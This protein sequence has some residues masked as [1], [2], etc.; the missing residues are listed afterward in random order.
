MSRPEP[1]APPY[2]LVKA[3]ETGNADAQ[4][5]LGR[6][7]A[8]NLP[9]TPYA[10]MW[11]RRAAAQGLPRALHNLGVLA[12][13]S[14]DHELAIEWFR[15]A[16]AA[17]W[18]NSMYLLGRLLE[19]KGDL[20]GAL[21][22]YNRGIAKDCT[23]SMHA[24]SKLIIDRQLSR[25][26]ESARNMC[27]RA[28]AQGHVGA[29]AQLAQI[30]HEGLGVQPDPKQAI[31]LW[32]KAAWQGHLGAQLMIGVTC[33]IG[34]YLK[35]DRVAAMRFLSA[36]AA[37][38][39]EGAEACLRRV[40]RNLTPEERAE[41]ERE[42]T[43]FAYLKSNHST[44]APP[45]HLLWAAEAGDVESQNDLGFWYSQHLP[46]SSEAQMWFTRAADQGD[47]N[48]RHNLGAEAF[49]AGDMPLAA[50]W[51]KKAIAAGTREY[52]IYLGTILERNGDAVGATEI[53]QRGADRN[54]PDCQCS[55][56]RLAFH[57][58]T[59]E[60]YGRAR[61]WDEKAA[62]HGIAASQ[63][64][65]GMMYHQGLGLEPDP[66]Q[67]VHW[68]QQAA[69]QGHHVAQYMMGVACHKGAGTSRDR[70]AAMRFLKASA[71]QGNQEAKDYL[72]DR[73]GRAY[74]WGI[75]RA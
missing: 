53:F 4:S 31:S 52:F 26:Y 63:A 1:S 58:R 23:N 18:R 40:E 46:E 11:F 67:A 72:N 28:V 68:W 73:G 59:E 35:E 62:A 27:E 5:D 29:R 51:F 50:E 14:E 10:Q 12:A 42:P 8:E 6:W 36:S 45:S 3:A 9:E 15:K 17:D 34:Q 24:M 75:V 38:G 2:D 16:V 21:K 57:E 74:A 66:G 22:V 20:E 43:L 13:Q 61:Y 19:E 71:A 65:L 60:S 37:Q 49:N 7:Y 25:H 39:N 44:E 32:L 69:Q 47:G 64:R 70:L 30:Y 55:L 41:F 54:C 33:D 48:A 56:G